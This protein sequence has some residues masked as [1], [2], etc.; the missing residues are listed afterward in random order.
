MNSLIFQYIII[1]VIFLAASFYLFK[2]ISKNFST[3]KQ[4]K[5][6]FGCDRECGH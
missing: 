5:G 6:E 4:K 1:A 3:K 2:I